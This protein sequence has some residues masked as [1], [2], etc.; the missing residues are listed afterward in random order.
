MRVFIALELPDDFAADVA[1][2]ARQLSAEV[3]GRFLRRE[4]YHLTLA[5]LGEVDE[6]ELASAVAA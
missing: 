2:L 5:F 6:A 3:D 1:G 4:S